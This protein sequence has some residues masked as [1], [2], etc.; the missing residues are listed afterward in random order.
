MK[1]RVLQILVLGIFMIGALS[2]GTP[3]LAGQGVR[4][5]TVTIDSKLDACCAAV[6][7]NFQTAFDDFNSTWTLLDAIGSKIENIQCYIN[8]DTVASKLELC[9]SAIDEN[10]QTIVQDFSSTWTLLNS[11]PPVI[12]AAIENCCPTIIAKV[13]V[14]EYT[15]ASKIDIVDQDL[16][17]FNYCAPIGITGPTT[18]TNA[19][20]YCLSN[21]INGSI[22]L[23]TTTTGVVINMNGHIIN[24]AT[25]QY[26][27]QLLG[28]SDVSVYNGRIVGNIGV[29]ATACE[30]I[31][32]NNVFFA[33]AGTA[34]ELQN[35]TNIAVQSCKLVSNSNGSRGVHAAGCSVVSFFDIYSNTNLVGFLFESTNDVQADTVQIV[36]TG[37]ACTG[38]YADSCNRVTFK[39]LTSTVQT[40]VVMNGCSTIIVAGAEITGN[41]GVTSTNCSIVTIDRASFESCISGIS[42]DTGSSFKITRSEFNNNDLAISLRNFD[43]YVEI[44]ECTFAKCANGTSGNPDLYVM[45]FENCN[46]ALITDCQLKQSGSNLIYNNLHVLYLLNCNDAIVRAVSSIKST[47]NASSQVFELNNCNRCMLANCLASDNTGSPARGYFLQDST[48]TMLSGCIATTIAQ[49][50][51]ELY[52]SS[53]SIFQQCKSYGHVGIYTT[54]FFIGNNSPNNTFVNCYAS[55]PQP[56]AYFSDGFVADSGDGNIFERCIAAN[57]YGHGFLYRT[58]NNTTTECQAL[59]NQGYPLQPPFWYYGGG[60]TNFN[61]NNEFYKNIACNNIINYQDGSFIPTYIPIIKSPADARGLDNV[62]CSLTEQD[63]LEV[64]DSKLDACCA[65]ATLDLEQTLTVVGNLNDSSIDPTTLTTASQIDALDVSVDELVKILLRAVKNV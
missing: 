11:V 26:A 48:N 34:L 49:N 3:P 59:Y 31:K 57:N 7:Q 63:L 13:D 39:N 18:I 54:C 25:E 19:G 51:F 61:A 58:S 15:A 38:I 44:S 10:F 30:N 32:L 37:N 14:C 60:F 29:F 5:I 1:P 21:D 46:N 62:D 9:C 50:G 64:V 20:S 55:S 6:E 28:Q 23:Q 12:V 40:N 42:G 27:I 17:Q 47:S 8:T 24:A 33:C 53:G 22:S 65:Q 56:A 16:T 52:G 45:Y 35:S 36:T 2:Y 43:P 4:N 41:S